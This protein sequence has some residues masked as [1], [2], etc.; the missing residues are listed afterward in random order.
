VFT[1]EDVRWLLTA[2]FSI[3]ASLGVAFTLLYHLA[4]HARGSQYREKRP[5]S[6]DLWEDVLRGLVHVLF[7]P[8]FL[9]LDRSALP[10]ITHSLRTLFGAG[11]APRPNLPRSPDRTDFDSAATLRYVEQDELGRA[12]VHET[13]R[14]EER[15]RRTVTLPCDSPELRHIWLLIGIARGQSGTLSLVRLYQT[16]NLVAEVTEHARIEAGQRRARRC[17]WCGGDLRPGDVQVPEPIY[18]RVLGP[19]GASCLVDGWAMRGRAT[20]QCAPCP[21]CGK[22]RPAT[23]EDVAGFGPAS[24]VVAALRQGVQFQLDVP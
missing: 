7:W 12:R 1:R 8:A 22:V 11:A 21:A 23:T 19:D 6:H 16:D 3:W 2:L 17:E 18:L 20:V 13:V 10:R 5:W 14:G 9:L 4:L 24:E 15:R